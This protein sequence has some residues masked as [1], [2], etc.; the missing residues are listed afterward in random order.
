MKLFVGFG[1]NDRDQ[2]IEEQVF[3]VLHGM[4]FSVVDGKDMHGQV[5]QDEVKSRIEQ[6]DLAIGFFTIREGQDQADFNSHIWVRD[7]MVHA[8]ARGKPLIPVIEDGAR[9]PDGLLGGRQYIL[10]RQDDRLA[11]VVELVEALGKKDIRRLKLDPDGDELRRNLQQWRRTANFVTQ[12]RTRDAGGIESA[13]RP[14][15]LELIDQGF[16]L[17]VSEVPKHAYVEV[18]GLLNGE[19]KFSSGWASADAV[20][21]KIF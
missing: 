8:L 14:G 1:Y 13:F 9:I 21:V 19:V 15:R 6:S 7:E 3:P 10:L 18:E 5:L 2:W 4:G 20:Q 12:Y 16:Y 17:N 11:C